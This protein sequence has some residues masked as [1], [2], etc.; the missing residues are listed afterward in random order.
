MISEQ[1]HSFFPQFPQPCAPQER[2]LGGHHG[3]VRGAS[4]LNRFTILELPILW[5]HFFWS[6]YTGVSTRSR[7]YRP[8]PGLCRGA[9]ATGGTAGVHASP[10][11]SRVDQSGHHHTRLPLAW[12]GAPARRRASEAA[13]CLGSYDVM[14]VGGWCSG[15]TQWR[16]R[17]VHGWSR[18]AQGAAR[19]SACPVKRSH[20][21]ET[22]ECARW[23]LLGGQ[24]VCTLGPGLQRGPQVQEG[25]GMNLRNP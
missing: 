15:T 1:L 23:A 12:G 7:A 6:L 22:C 13:P 16:L 2:R 20:G 24:G 10:L 21:E 5:G 19:L 3:T 9:H 25:L 17:P 11:R 18:H 4:C 14:S 8:A